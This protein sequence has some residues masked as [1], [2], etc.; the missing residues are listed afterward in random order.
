MGGIDVANAVA[1]DGA[2]YTYLTGETTS[3][4][5]PT[6]PGAFDSTCGTDGLCNGDNDA[7]VAKLTSHGTR[8]WVTYIGGGRGEKPTGIAV[9][10]TGHAYITG[11]TSSPTYPVS[12]LSGA[13]TLKTPF[14]FIT[15]FNQSGSGLVYSVRFCSGCFGDDLAL[16]DRARTTLQLWLD[17]VV[18]LGQ[19][20]VALQSK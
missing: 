15:K 4:H 1:V 5:F 3:I 19:S 11:W 13:P 18:P 6:T 16:R 17:G 20:F 8:V 2:G 9:D 7:F 14:A 12:P 10:T